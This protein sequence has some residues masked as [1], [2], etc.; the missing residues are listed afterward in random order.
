M[1]G[2]AGMREEFEA[3]VLQW[4]G[5]DV[6]YHYR[7]QTAGILFAWECWKQ[8]ATKTKLCEIDGQFQA[9]AMARDKVQ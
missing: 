2:E 3:F 1:I 5:R 7:N 8:S 9:I 4:T 6:E